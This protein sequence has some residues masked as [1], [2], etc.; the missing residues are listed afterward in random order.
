MRVDF[1]DYL[2]TING[3]K[4]QARVYAGGNSSMSRDADGKVYGWGDNANGQ[5]SSA[6]VNATT[7]HYEIPQGDSVNYNYI[8][9]DRDYDAAIRSD[10]TGD[11]PFELA[12]ELD[13]NTRTSVIYRA[14]GTVWAM[15][16]SD[17]AALSGDYAI[18]GSRGT[19]G[20][21]Y[22]LSLIHI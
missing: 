17:A 14:D 16:T 6:T 12:L 18:T 3:G 19:L 11:E 22:N 5:L 9:H 21:S 2:D 7:A 20:D 1:T 15:G 8:D 10:A 13:V 4:A